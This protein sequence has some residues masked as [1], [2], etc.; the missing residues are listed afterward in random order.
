MLTSSRRSGFARTW[1]PVVLFV[2]LLAAAFSNGLRTTWGLQWPDIDEQGAGV[3][4]YRDMGL[5]QT[6]IDSGYGPDP[7]YLGERTWY[8]PLTAAMIAVVSGATG[9]PVHV[10]ATQIGAYADILA[11]ICFFVMVAVLFGRWTALFASTGFLFLLSGNLPSWD[12]ATYSPWF[13]PVNFVQTVFYLLVT[14]FYLALRDGRWQAFVL[15]GVLWG[16]TFLGHTAPALVFGGMATTWLVATWWWTRHGALHEALGVRAAFQRYCLMMA[17]ALLV[18]APLVAPIVGHYGLQVRNSQPSSLTEPLLG[19]ELPK[20][21]RLHLTVPA[22]VALLG[23]WTVAWRRRRTTAGWLILAWCAVAAG[24]L[25]Y[26]FLRLAVKHYFG[27]VMPSIV[28]SFHFLFYLK[29]ASAVFFG[30]GVTLIGRAIGAVSARRRWR[31]R[32][33]HSVLAMGHAVGTIVC[34]ILLAPH[35]HAFEDRPDFAAARR[36]A[37][38]VAES[39]WLRVFEWLLEHHRPSDVALAADRECSFVCAPSGTKAVYAGPGF[40]NPYVD[41]E[42]RR[43]ARDRMFEALDKDNS[44]AFHALAAPYDVVYVIT[45]SPRSESYDTNTP[46]ALRLAFSAGR[47]RVFVVKDSDA[48]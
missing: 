22:A 36:A 29:A 31:A 17:L 16:V 39:D 41:L 8:N 42:P 37:L 10:V 35:V 4:L 46:G 11:P 48:R 47:F 6:M 7:T 19:P 44:A 5:A 23:G 38:V 14:A 26:S 20:L 24:F 40:S 21:L 1:L 43:L 12:S 30:I 15:P 33:P 9:S 28:P 32:G 18:S 13:I 25:V 27:P 45:M 2:G 34:M 3:D